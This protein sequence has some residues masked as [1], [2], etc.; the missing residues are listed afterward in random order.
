MQFHK[1]LDYK[2]FKKPEFARMLIFTWAYLGL[3][4]HRTCCWSSET[5]ILDAVTQATRRDC[6][7]PEAKTKQFDATRLV[8][9]IKAGF[10]F[11]CT[12]ILLFWILEWI[13][14]APLLHFLQ[15][16]DICM[17]VGRERII[18]GVNKWITTWV[19]HELKKNRPH[20]CSKSSQLLQLY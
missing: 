4:S 19:T 9:S 1:T 14:L 3:G 17:N 10:P 16:C 11:C 20:R 2:W 5:N 7:K 8:G 12:C 13:Q 18:A 6:Y 15:R